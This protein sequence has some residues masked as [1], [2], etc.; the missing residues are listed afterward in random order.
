MPDMPVTL[1]VDP[2]PGVA[3]ERLHADAPRVADRIEALLDLLET[4]PGHPSLRRR[5]Y[6]HPAPLW[7]FVV[8]VGDEDYLVL[9]EEVDAQTVAVVYL[10]PDL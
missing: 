3:L 6:R 10:G 1:L 9:W 5:A 7:G 4:N 2:E 8:H